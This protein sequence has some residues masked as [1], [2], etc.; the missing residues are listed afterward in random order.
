MWFDDMFPGLRAEG[1]TVTSD[2]TEDYNCIAWAAGDQSAWW[3]HA[4]GYRWPNA[5]RTPLIESLVEIFVGLGYET[6]DNA[7]LEDGFEKVALYARGPLWKHAAQQLPSGLWTSKLG[8]DEDIQHATPEALIG[9]HY[10]VVHCIM[11]RRH[12]A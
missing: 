6:C 11:R 1:Y 4:V 7:S 10:G 9:D 12:H 2:H 3:S 8:P 5:K